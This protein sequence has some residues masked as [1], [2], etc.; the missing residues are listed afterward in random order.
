MHASSSPYLKGFLAWS[1]K[2][3]WVSTL[4]KVGLWGEEKTVCQQGRQRQCAFRTEEQSCNSKIKQ[5]LQS[6]SHGSPDHS[7]PTGL[8]VKKHSQR[9]CGSTPA[10]PQNWPVAK[11]QIPEG[12]GCQRGCQSVKLHFFPLV[13]LFSFFVFFLKDLLCFVCAEGSYNLKTSWYVST[14]KRHD[15]LQS[16]SSP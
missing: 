1:D 10:P 2:C 11:T 5:K 3:F 8:P 12:N 6:K 9:V 13:L 16:S 4:E 7:Q 15:W 14:T